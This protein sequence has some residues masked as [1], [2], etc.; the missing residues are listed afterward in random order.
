MRLDPEVHQ[1]LTA[2][3]KRLESNG[4][5]LGGRLEEMARER[6]YLAPD[7]KGEPR[8]KTF[9]EFCQAE[10]RYKSDS[11]ACTLIRAHQIY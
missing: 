1:E 6:H 4:F 2:S 8:Y 11:P 10:L 9:E 7:E 3:I 5:E